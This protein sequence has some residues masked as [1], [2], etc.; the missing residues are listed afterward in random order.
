MV[1]D[2]RGEPGPVC[3]GAGHEVELRQR[4]RLRTPLPRAEEHHGTVA[5]AAVNPGVPD[6]H[7]RCTVER[8]GGGRAMAIDCESRRCALP[9][10]GFDEAGYRGVLQGN[11]AAGA[12]DARAIWALRLGEPGAYL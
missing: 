8:R 3:L 2:G 5:A 6:S 10:S 4:R 9:E 11:R 12:R 1:P 7:R